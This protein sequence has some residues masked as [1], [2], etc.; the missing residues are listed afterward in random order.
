M[1]T[2]VR[3]LASLIFIAQ[4]YLAMVIVALVFAIPAIISRNGAFA[5][6]HLSSNLT[7]EGSKPWNAPSPSPQQ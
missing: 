6:V 7:P 1:P 5:A 4:M 3:W 2:P